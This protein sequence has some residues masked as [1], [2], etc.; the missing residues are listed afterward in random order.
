MER[1][2]ARRT[3]GIKSGYWSWAKKDELIQRLGK[4]EDIGLEPKELMKA[5][6]K[7]DAKFPN[8]EGD[9]YDGDGNLVYDTWICPCCQ[10]AYEIECQK[11]KYCP[12]CG[13]KIRWEE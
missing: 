1:L 9:G 3:N 12:E 6:S 8:I 7:Q 4:Y 2:T 13:Q 10:T 11:Y 5:K